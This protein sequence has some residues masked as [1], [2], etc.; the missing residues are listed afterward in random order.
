MLTRSHFILPA[1]GGLVQQPLLPQCITID[2][3]PDRL[4]SLIVRG[5]V[6]SHIMSARHL[7]LK[8]L[9]AV[10]LNKQTVEGMLLSQKAYCHGSLQM[11]YSCNL[12]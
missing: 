1:H 3:Y 2:L 10:S 9:A 12:K 7:K 5:R 8:M 4:K 11:H 6:E